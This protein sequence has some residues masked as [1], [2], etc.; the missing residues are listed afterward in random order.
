M[1]LVS[2]A[3]SNSHYSPSSF[4]PDLGGSHHL[5]CVY[6]APSS[7]LLSVMHQRATVNYNTLF[8]SGWMLISTFKVQLT[9]YLCYAT[10]YLLLYY[11]LETNITLFTP[12]SGSF[13]CFSDDSFSCPF[14]PV[15]TMYFQSLLIFNF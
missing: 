8:T 2:W 3:V 5:K 14:F 13:S 15:K 11:I 6:M 1:I 12:L 4:P 9:L 7:G 10:L